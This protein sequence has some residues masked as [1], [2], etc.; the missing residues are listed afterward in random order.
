M[1]SDHDQQRF[2]GLTLRLLTKADAIRSDADTAD[3]LG[4]KKI[5]SVHQMHGKNVAIVSQPTSRVIKADGLITQTP[6]LT[7]TIRAADCQNLL[8]YVPK[9]K[10]IGL[11]HAGWRGLVCGAIP[12]FFHTL[13]EHFDV[14]GKDALVYAGPSLCMRCS[15]FTDPAR[16]LPNI[17]PKFFSGKYVDLRGI[18]D[19]QLRYCGVIMENVTRHSDCTRCKPDLYWTYRGGDRE[20]VMEGWTNVLCASM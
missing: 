20:K 6:G 8:V 1:I 12:S 19:D 4:T 2:L 11:L 15:D 10:V 5:A 14:A 13:K 18:A 3:R 16:E 9:Q 7:L 17:D